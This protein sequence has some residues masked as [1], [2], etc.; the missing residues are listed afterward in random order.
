MKLFLSLAAPAAPAG[1][2]PADQTPPGPQFQVPILQE[3]PRAQVLS[4][5]HGVNISVYPARG[6]KASLR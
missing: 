2:V 4:V 6:R 5:V 3:L 1:A